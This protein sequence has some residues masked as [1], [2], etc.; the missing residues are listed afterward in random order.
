MHSTGKRFAE[1]QTP[2][3]DRHMNI[4]NILA[5]Q[6]LMSKTS[7]FLT[8]AVSQAVPVSPNRTGAKIQAGEM[9]QAQRAARQEGSVMDAYRSGGSVLAP[10]TKRRMDESRMPMRGASDSGFSQVG[11]AVDALGLGRRD[12]FLAD[13]LRRPR[14]QNLGERGL[15]NR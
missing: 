4:I 6:H 12:S 7:G 1:K 3:V 10:A 8:D 2:T 13:S 15:V 14:A 11:R 5:M 9:M